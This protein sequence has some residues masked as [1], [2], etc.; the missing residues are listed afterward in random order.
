M[1]PRKMCTENQKC[2]TNTWT[3]C[4]YVT[5]KMPQAATG[6]APFELVYG[7]TVRGPLTLLKE[8][9]A[10]EPEEVVRTIYE[11]VINIREKVT[12]T[13]EAV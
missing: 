12:V 10:E 13:M 7:R 8:Q 4:C 2:S 6:H 3:H 11:Y 1:M 9:W 5:E